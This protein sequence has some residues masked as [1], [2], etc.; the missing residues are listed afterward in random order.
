M[1]NTEFHYYNASRHTKEKRWE[2]ICIS[3]VNF[4]PLTDLISIPKLRYVIQSH[5]AAKEYSFPTVRRLT[6]ISTRIKMVDWNFPIPTINR[7]DYKLPA[8]ILQ[9]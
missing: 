5:T 4:L 1:S 2:Y 8:D 7:M 3:L 9:I 6:R